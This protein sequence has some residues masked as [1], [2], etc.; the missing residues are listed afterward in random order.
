M[1]SLLL[2]WINHQSRLFCHILQG[3]NHT[4]HHWCVEPALPSSYWHRYK[5]WVTSMRCKG[6]SADTF[7]RELLLQ[8]HLPRRCWKIILHACLSVFP[9]DRS[10]V[11]TKLIRICL[12]LLG[13]YSPKWNHWVRKKAR[14]W[15][16]IANISFFLPVY[17]ISSLQNKL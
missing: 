1:L 14:R 6:G 2:E 11:I 8:Q 17:I 10:A 7:K 4:S 5:L 3:W 16:R 13:S 12:E 9:T 15:I